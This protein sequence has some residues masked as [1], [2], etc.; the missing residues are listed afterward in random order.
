MI[1]E[2]GKAVCEESEP[3]FLFPGNIGRA[4]FV[5]KNL[6]LFTAANDLEGDKNDQN[7]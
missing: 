6:G 7:E 5:F 1:G 3:G 2:T 4:E